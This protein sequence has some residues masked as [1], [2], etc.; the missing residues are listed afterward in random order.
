MEQP[1]RDREAE[2]GGADS[3]EKTTY[4]GNAHGAALPDHTKNPAVTAAVR[5]TGANPVVWVTAFLA[6]VVV[7]AYLLGFF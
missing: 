5:P 4:A 6:L 7:L 2:L 3:I 1:E